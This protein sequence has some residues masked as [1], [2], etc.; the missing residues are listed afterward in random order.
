MKR[1]LLPILAFVAI[2]LLP[3]AGFAQVEVE[4][5]KQEAAKKAEKEMKGE[6]VEVKKEEASKLVDKNAKQQ[7]KPV[8]DEGANKKTKKYIRPSKDKPK[9]AI[10]RPIKNPKGNNVTIG[11]KIEKKDKNKNK[12]KKLHTVKKMN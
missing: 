7:A 10:I 6:V 11:K 8:K 5:T 4:P 9:E 3:Q 1:I 2:A 12:K